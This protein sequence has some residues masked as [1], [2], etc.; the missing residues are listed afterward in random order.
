LVTF[1]VTNEVDDDDDDDDD[2]D[3]DSLQIWLCSENF[4]TGWTL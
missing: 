1:T 3:D 4:F 2:E